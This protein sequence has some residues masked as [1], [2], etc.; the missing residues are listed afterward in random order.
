MNDEQKQTQKE[1]DDWY[2][3]ARALV[4]DQKRLWDADRLGLPDYK[5]TATELAYEQVK[6]Q[7]LIG[8]KSA[9]ATPLDYDT[10]NL[11]KE[12]VKFL[13]SLKVGV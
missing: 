9:S 1:I 5:R 10:L 2:A 6:Q 7:S 11:T 3:R 12:D 13:D 4:N 8:I